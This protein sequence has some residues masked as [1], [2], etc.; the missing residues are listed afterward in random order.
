MDGRK[1]EFSPH[2]AASAHRSGRA[3]GRGDLFIPFHNSIDDADG[4]W[5]E[6]RSSARALAHPP[7]HERAAHHRTG[8][9]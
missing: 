7:T 8:R 5:M 1:S 6:S 4:G 2:T 3:R 9:S